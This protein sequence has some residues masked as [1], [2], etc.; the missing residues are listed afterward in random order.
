M[1]SIFYILHILVTPFNISYIK[2]NLNNDQT[3]FR[4]KYLKEGLSFS[5]YCFHSPMSY[6]DWPWRSDFLKYLKNEDCLRNV[7]TK[8]SYTQIEKNIICILKKLMMPK[9]FISKTK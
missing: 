1:F 4:I 7:K 5:F 3:Y 2:C 8:F 6:V 9:Y